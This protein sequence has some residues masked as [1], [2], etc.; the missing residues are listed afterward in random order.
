VKNTLK[1]KRIVTAMI[2]T[3][4]MGWLIYSAPIMA[5]RTGKTRI[6]EFAMMAFESMKF[7][8]IELKF[9][10]KSFLK[11]TVKRINVKRLRVIVNGTVVKGCEMPRAGYD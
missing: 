11:P 1:A 2:I 8:P 6:I 4:R 5:K 9:S 10:D 3:S 7:L